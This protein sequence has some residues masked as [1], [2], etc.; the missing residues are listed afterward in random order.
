MT[1]K[2]VARKFGKIKNIAPLQMPWDIPWH[3]I[4]KMGNLYA[5]ARNQYGNTLAGPVDKTSTSMEDLINAAVDDL[6]S[7]RT[8]PVQVAVV[9]NGVNPYLIDGPIKIHDYVS[10][11]GKGTVELKLDDGA[12]CN[13]FEYESAERNKI[14]EIIGFGFD[15]NRDNNTSGNGIYCEENTTFGL[16]RKKVI[17]YCNFWEIDESAINIVGTN[18]HSARYFEIDHV[19]VRPMVSDYA[20]YLER[21]YDS[22]IRHCHLGSGLLGTLYAK[23]CANIQMHE[24]YWTGCQKVNIEFEA[25]D[26]LRMTQHYIDDG[27]EPGM[28]CGGTRNSQFYGIEVHTPNGVPPTDKSGIKLQTAGGEHSVNNEFDEIRVLSS[29]AVQWKYGIEE[30]DANQDYNKYSVNGKECVTAALRILGVN[31]VAE[32]VIGKVVLS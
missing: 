4:V 1:P 19:D 21:F 23:F 17:R 2:L 22:D 10:F 5:K 30:V 26:K 29:D 24:I 20:V 28:I 7:G 27:Y 25:M 13:I 11:Q 31:S 14:W 9:G 8:Y 3:S 6:P 18:G 12:N 15:G 16:E 32:S